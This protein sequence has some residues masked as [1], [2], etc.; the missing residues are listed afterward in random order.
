MA[1]KQ[2]KGSTGDTI[3]GK[4]GNNAT[5]VAIGK[6]IHTSGDTNVAGN[7]I[8]NVEGDYSVSSA[9]AD[10][11]KQLANRAEENKARLDEE[12]RNYQEVREQAKQASTW[13]LVAAVI[14]FIL[15]AVAVVLFLMNST[16]TSVVAGVVSA[17][18]QVVAAFF[19]NQVKSANDRMEKYHEQ[20]MTTQRERTAF[21]VVESMEDGPAKDR[22]IEKIIT[23]LLPEKTQ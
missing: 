18:S 10:S 21:A 16:T 23:G 15:V 20:L 11:D 14:G 1:T 2:D 19:A 12:L 7:D 6:D 17:I 3:T 13:S 9:K 8:V 5:N 22:M 4:V